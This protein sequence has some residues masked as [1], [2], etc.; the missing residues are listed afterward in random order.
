MDGG[1]CAAAQPEVEHCSDFLPQTDSAVA[2][3]SA[4][5]LDGLLLAQA[6]GVAALSRVQA[7]IQRD[8]ALQER[9]PPSYALA[10]ARLEGLG[11]AVTVTQFQAACLMESNASYCLGRLEGQGLILRVPVAGDRRC[12]EVGIS[13]AGRTWLARLRQGLAA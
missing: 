1:L 10:L 11:R 6:A 3:A 9:I 8:F 13:A 12:S 2:S 5:A 7:A 4:G